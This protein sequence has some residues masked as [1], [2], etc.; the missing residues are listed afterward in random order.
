M[1]GSSSAA[2]Q[3]EKGKFGWAGKA[4]TGAHRA[5]ATAHEE[6]G[7]GPL[8]FAVKEVS[9]VFHP[10]RGVADEGNAALA[11][12]GMARELEVERVRLV[13][14]FEGIRFVNKGDDRGV[15]MVAFPSPARVRMAAPVGI[16]AVEEDGFPFDREGGV[17][18][19]E[20]AHPGTLDFLFDFRGTALPA[21]V[22]AGAGEDAVRCVEVTEDA[23]AFGEGGLVCG[24]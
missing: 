1:S 23:E 5:N 18:V 13:K 6:T 16:E 12:V 11:S 15:P 22:V 9:T 3:S 20:V 24:D 17:G 10:G 14:R 19:A 4:D 7:S 8:V 21:V 2:S